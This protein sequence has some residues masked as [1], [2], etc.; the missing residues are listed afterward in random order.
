MTRR[1]LLNSATA[2]AAPHCGPNPANAISIRPVR[3]SPL[4]LHRSVGPP[5]VQRRHTEPGPD[6]ERRRAFPQRL[7]HHVTVLAQPGVHPDRPIHARAPGD[8]QLHQ[9]D[10]KLPTFPRLCA[11]T[12][13][14][15]RSSANGTWGATPRAARALTA[16]S[17]SAARASTSTRRS[18]STACKA[19][20]GQHDRRAHCGSKALHP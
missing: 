4:R 3:R 13:T 5:L 20:P 9:L 2:A 7:R 16:G 18:T 6:R 17:A 1:Q 8:G 15:R 11:R 14:A 12:A 10:N 19:G